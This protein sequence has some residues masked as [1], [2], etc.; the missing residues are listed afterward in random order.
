MF[1]KKVKIFIRLRREFKIEVTFRRHI[2]T[3]LVNNS[4]LILI[5]CGIVFGTLTTSIEKWP[6]NLDDIR[7]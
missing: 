5:L 7:I 4:A 3:N 6:T 1:R 2:F